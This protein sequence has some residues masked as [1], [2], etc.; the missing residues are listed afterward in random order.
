MVVPFNRM[1][2]DVACI[3][4]HDLDF[5]INKMMKC[6]NQTMAPQGKCTWIMTNLVEKGKAE[7]DVSLG[8]IKRWTVV[9]RCGMRIGIIGIAERDWVHTFKDLEVEVEYLNY[10]RCA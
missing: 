6:L 10:K 9:E 5:G 7:G 8:G 1:E 2:V 3:G 4:N